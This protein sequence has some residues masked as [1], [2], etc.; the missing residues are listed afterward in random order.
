MVMKC[1]VYAPDHLG[2]LQGRVLYGAR[3]DHSLTT[4]K[5]G[6]DPGRT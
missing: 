6:G 2:T 4:D 5:T 3:E 1:A